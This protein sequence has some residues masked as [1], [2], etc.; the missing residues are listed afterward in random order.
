[1]LSTNNAV[2]YTLQKKGFF[3]I[4]RKLLWYLFNN[5]KDTGKNVNTGKFYKN[6]GKTKKPASKMKPQRREKNIA[7]KEV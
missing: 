6:N 5:G 3:T 1:L 4:N 7:K 2:E